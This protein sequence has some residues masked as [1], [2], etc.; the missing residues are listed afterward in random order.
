MAFDFGTL[1]S[2]TLSTTAGAGQS[3]AFVP[4]AGEL[5]ICTPSKCGTTLMQQIVQSLRTG[6]DMTFEEISL[7]IPFIELHHAYSNSDLGGP[8]PGCIRAFK[9]HRVKHWCPGGFRKECK[10]IYV[11]RNPVDVATSLYHF[12]EGWIFPRG[13]V[14]AEEFV[15]NVFLAAGEPREVCE[16]PSTWHHLLS[17]YPKRNAPNMLFLF[18]EDLVQHKRESV[19][20]VA[21]FLGIPLDAALEAVVLQQSSK[22]SMAANLSKYDDHPLKQNTNADAGL[23]Q[24]AGSN[25]GKVRSAP[26]AQLSEATLAALEQ[27]WVELMEPVTGCASYEAFRAHTNAELGRPF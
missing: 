17:W 1:K 6:G 26:K 18:Y 22:E 14:T 13:A 11:I 23:P 12:L 3:G 20:L 4:Q 19:K 21:D 10:Y 8:Q 15:N 9:T 7:V 16:R 2:I 5:L 25:A 24:D 27:R